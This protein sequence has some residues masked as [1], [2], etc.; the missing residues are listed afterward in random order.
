MGSRWVPL[1]ALARLAGPPTKVV[2]GQEHGHGRRV[3]FELPAEANRQPIE[4][5]KEH[6]DRHVMPLDMTRANRG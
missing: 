6:A 3:V 2:V 1:A 5:A 4:P